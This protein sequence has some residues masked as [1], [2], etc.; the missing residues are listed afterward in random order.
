MNDR[1]ALIALRAAGRLIV[2]IVDKHQCDRPT[3]DPYGAVKA[4]HEKFDLARSDRPTFQGVSAHTLRAC[5]IEEETSEVLQALKGRDLAHIARELADL[6]YTTYGTAVSLGI[7]IRPVFEA[8]DAS[9]MAKVGGAVR[10]DGKV[11]K[12]PGWEPP[13]IEAIIAAQQPGAPTTEG[14][15]R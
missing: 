11:L 13:D 5:L 3:F 6:L 14:Q 12:P 10:A 8:V 4:F 15:T 2:D 1:D 9:N 7:D